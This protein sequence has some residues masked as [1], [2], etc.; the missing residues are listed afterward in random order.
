MSCV[1]ADV[2]TTT[3]TGIPRWSVNTWRLVPILDLSVG[4]G[5]TCHFPPKDAFTDMLSGDYCHV[6]LIPLISS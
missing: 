1:F 3:D 4:L 6:H 5:P 2:I